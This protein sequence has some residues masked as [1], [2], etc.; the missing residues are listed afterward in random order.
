MV[1]RRLSDHPYILTTETYDI[2]RIANMVKEVPQSW[3][4]ADGTNVTEDFLTY[5]S[6]L[7]Q[8]EVLPYTVNGLPRHLSLKQQ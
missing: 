4:S 3:I 1:F 5:C 7:I 8:G 6:P 2:N